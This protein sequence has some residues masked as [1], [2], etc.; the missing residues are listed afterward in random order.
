MFVFSSLYHSKIAKWLFVSCI[1]VLNGF[2]IKE[3]KKGR[4]RREEMKKGRRREEEDEEENEKK[5][6]HR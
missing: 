3:K 2:E 5:K 6:E 4:R 1:S